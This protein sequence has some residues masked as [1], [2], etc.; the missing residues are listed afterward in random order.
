[1]YTGSCL[2][3]GLR[4]EIDGELDTIQ[5]CHCGQCRKAQGTAM[6]TNAP[7]PSERFRIVAGADLL[8]G[9]ESSAGKQRMFCSRCGSP[10]ISRR[11]DMP[12]VVRVRVGAIDGPINARPV[13]HFWVG[14]KADWWDINDELP[15]FVAGRAR[16]EQRR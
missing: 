4:F 2:C 10:I 16:T 6:A 15:Q 8:R 13:A 9:F 1:M 11:D 12:E 7:V 5:V 3:G 14:S